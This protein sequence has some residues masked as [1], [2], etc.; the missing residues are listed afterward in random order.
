MSRPTFRVGGLW[1]QTGDERELR[2][3]DGEVE[4]VQTV[5]FALG[6]A[7]QDLVPYDGE[8]PC[9]ATTFEVIVGLNGVEDGVLV[10]PYYPSITMINCW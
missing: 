10:T 3:G 7:S 8:E 1:W 6:R 4:A 5:Q 9:R 2:C